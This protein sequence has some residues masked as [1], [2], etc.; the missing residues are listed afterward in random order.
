MAALREL[1]SAPAAVIVTGAMAVAA[2]AYETAGGRLRLLEA[3]A[4]LALAGAVLRWTRWAFVAWL[5]VVASVLPQRMGSLSAGGARSDV[6]EALGLLIIAIVV[7]RW[8]LDDRLR[9]P[10]LAWP[11]LTLLAAGAV[12]AAVTAS[13]GDPHTVWLAALKTLALYLIVPAAVAIHRTAA[14]VDALERWLLRIAVVG[15]SLSLVSVAFGLGGPSASHT[16]TINDMAVDA[17]RARPAVLHLVVLA[18][19]LLI[20]RVAS[21][22][23][24]WRRAL[25]IGLFTTSLALS[26]TRST[27]VPAVAAIL[28]FVIGRP[29]RRVAL[30]GIR[31]GVVVAVLATAA[32]GA[33]STGWLG[34][35]MQAVVARAETLGTGDQ[36][37]QSLS[38]QHRLDENTAAQHA[39]DGHR[40]LGIGLGEPYGVVTVERDP[41]TGTTSREP[42]KFIHNSYLGT[43]LGMGLLGLLAWALLA[44]GVTRR[45]WQARR[46]HSP[47]GDRSLAAACALLAIGIEAMFQT[48]LFFRP[49]IATV[50]CAV[51]FLLGVPRESELLR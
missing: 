27:W 46:D 42:Q 39:L 44:V 32:I 51:V 31:T 30:R 34:P 17:N 47:A 2:L 11:F 5:V 25:A 18:L 14:D 38:Y 22:R 3:L 7:L 48:D 6:G 40:V 28:L 21:D 26:F 41:M 12:G 15:S 23:M 33:A 45:A 36:L 50:A 16:V 4:A 43:W 35:S 37:T 20:A 29:G 8:A 1:P 10:G 49:V 13:N 9:R 19:L 24:T